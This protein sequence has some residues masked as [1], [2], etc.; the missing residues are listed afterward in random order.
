MRTCARVNHSQ[1]ALPQP[2]SRPVIVALP[3]TLKHSLRK[4]AIAT[5]EV[6]DRVCGMARRI[7]YTDPLEMDLEIYRLRVKS[8]SLH[9]AVPP[10]GF[11]VLGKGI[12]PRAFP[13]ML[14]AFW[15]ASSLPQEKTCGTRRIEKQ[16]CAKIMKRCM[17]NCARRK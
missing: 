8:A 16:I 10:T 3:G 7:G 12:A 17:L 9:T 15:G 4:R 11:F 6:P 1:Q 14:N 5:V 2:I 13:G